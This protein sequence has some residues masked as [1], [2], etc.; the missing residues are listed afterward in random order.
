MLS[1]TIPLLINPPPHSYCSATL[2]VSTNDL[3][4]TVVFQKVV[5]T[6]EC[7]FILRCASLLCGHNICLMGI[8]LS[9]ALKEITLALVARAGYY[10]LQ[11]WILVTGCH[12]FSLNFDIFCSSHKLSTC[13]LQII[14]CISSPEETYF[15]PTKYLDST[16]HCAPSMPNYR[17][18][19]II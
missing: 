8:R 1:R 18:S 11:W 2:A 10:E 19:R 14:H 13:L 9:G 3:S 6:A 5:Y 4:C 15:L 12:H 16:I 7:L 17:T